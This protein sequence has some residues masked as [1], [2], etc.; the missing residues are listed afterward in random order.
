MGDEARYSTDIPVEIISPD[1]V[2]TRLGTMRFTDGFPDDATVDKV[3]D[4]LDFLRGVQA[5]LTAMPAALQAAQRRGIRKYGPDNQTV[6]IFEQL[7][8]SRSLFLTANTE[9]VYAIAWLNLSSG[10]IVVDSPPGMLGLVD[11]FWF[12]YVTDIGLAGPDQGRGGR[13]LFLPPDYQGDVPADGYFVCRSNTYGN[14]LGLR[15]FLHDGDPAPAA[16]AITEGLRIYPLAVAAD[17][18]EMNFVNASGQS[19]NTIHATDFTFF[20]EVDEVVQEEPNSAIDPETLGLLAS[21]GIVKGTQFAPDSRMKA[22]LVEAA[23]VG[24]ATARANAYRSRLDGAYFYPDSAWCTPFVG[25]SYLF[26]H[27]GVRL[28][29][30]RSFMFFAATGITP[31]MAIQ[32]VGAGSAY[33][34]AFVDAHSQPFDG[35]TTYR[36]HLPSGIPARTFWSLVL[37][38]TQTRSMLQTDQQFPSLGSQKPGVAANP[39]GS[40]DIYFAPDPPDGH[41]NNWMQTRPG[42]GWFVILRLYGPEQ[43][44]FDKTWRPGEIEAIT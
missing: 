8:D 30:A 32:R 16:R 26:E 33:A 28:L 37:Y 38:D 15:G 14:I 21:V 31:A 44:W 1:V 11:D 13:Y 9:N 3:F 22:V 27:D 7:M 20:E 12:H 4:N 25:G 35:A 19:M 24:N 40:F 5:F 39:D 43:S 36:L 34:A 42:K 23:A 6:L 2:E 17:P 29:D 18:P 41:E 10:P